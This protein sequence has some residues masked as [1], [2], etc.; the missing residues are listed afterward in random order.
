[1]FIILCLIRFSFLRHIL[2]R[3]SAR[4]SLSLAQLN[5]RCHPMRS[6]LVVVVVD[7]YICVCVCVLHLFNF[8]WTV[9]CLYRFYLYEFAVYWL[10]QGQVQLLWQSL[11]T[12]RSHVSWLVHVTVCVC[13][14]AF[15]SST[16]FPLT[17]INLHVLSRS[18]SLLVAQLN[19]PL[20]R[21]LCFHVNFRCALYAKIW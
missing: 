8:N 12:S 19:P 13:M 4:L 15:A 17:Y 1:M 10:W 9:Y 21:P 16:A 5:K 2:L 20:P 18:F 6:C 3:S 14:F 7:T 11:F